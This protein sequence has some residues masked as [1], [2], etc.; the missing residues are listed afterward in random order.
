MG[1]PLAYFVDESSSGMWMSH[2]LIRMSEWD[3]LLC[4]WVNKSIRPRLDW[5]WLPIFPTNL[6][7]SLSNEEMSSWRR[8]AICTRTAP[9]FW[10]KGARCQCSLIIYSTPQSKS[11]YGPIALWLPT[12]HWRVVKCVPQKQ[13]A[14]NDKNKWYRDNVE[15]TCIF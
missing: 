4:K 11:V 2:P 6:V 15:L 5:F 8:W 7:R 14:S 12:N 10:N 3:I 1:H 13:N 9:L